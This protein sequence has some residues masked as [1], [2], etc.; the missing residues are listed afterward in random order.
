MAHISQ[1]DAINRRAFLE[2]AS[3]LAIAGVAAPFAMQLAAMGD[4]AAFNGDDYRAMV[5]VFLFGGNDHANTLIPYDLP[6]YDLYSAIRG[7]GAGRTTGG[8][9]L[10]LDTL[11]PTRL[12]PRNNQVL[13]YNQQLALAPGMTNFKARFD[14]GKLAALLNVGPLT[15]PLTKAQYES[16]DTVTY[17]RP[18]KL[19]SHNDQQSIWQSLLPEG[20]TT[21]WGGRIA[22]Y[23][24][25]SNGSASTFTCISPAG[26]LVFLWGKS[27]F[28][29]Q[30]STNGALA[31]NGIKNGLYG[32]AKGGETLQ[33]LMTQQR[34]HLFE[35]DY[36]VIA[37][38][39]IDA[40]A[41]VT[42]ALKNVN[43]TTSFTQTGNS[44]ADQLRIVARLI[45]ARTALGVK[46]QVFIV[47]LGGFDLHDN[48][49]AQQPILLGRLDFAMDA[50]HRAMVELGVQDKVTTFT[51]SEFGRTLSSNGDGSD[52]GWG[53]HHFMLG[54]AVKGGRF[55]GTAPEISVTGNEQVGQ[56][57]LL[58]T[59]SVDQYGA[60]VGSWF[61]CSSSELGSIFPNLSRFSPQNLDFL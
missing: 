24:L 42:A 22:D 35:Q 25:A 3:R 31:V 51:A 32:S 57:R 39:S 19:F 54:G 61:G 7:G 17:T 47:S 28:A 59:T 2:R 27:A 46:R 11:T 8:I 29:Y 40:E 26:N 14:E 49:M 9:A 55:Y 36:N 53:G 5:C 33:Q 41:A 16:R 18:D 6:N 38:R 52:H 48:L 10:G 12:T 45:G 44:L 23:A 15:Q 50:F 4:A 13:A 34:T 56:G 20:A 37:K 30:V 58:P 60:T 21:G 43:L 1:L